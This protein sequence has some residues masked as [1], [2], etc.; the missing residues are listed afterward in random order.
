[1][2]GSFARIFPILS[3]FIFDGSVVFHIVPPFLPT[4]AI[5]SDAFCVCPVQPIYWL[6][7]PAGRAPVLIHTLLAYRLPDWPIF[8]LPQTSL[9]RIVAQATQPYVLQIRTSS[10]PGFFCVCLRWAGA[11]SFL[12]QLQSVI[13]VVFVFGPLI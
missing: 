9:H 2:L 3:R 11:Y 7:C 10:V 1:M 8:R 6:V 13:R 5:P 4:I 12:S